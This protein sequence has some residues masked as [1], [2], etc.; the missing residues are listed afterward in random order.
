MQATSDVIELYDASGRVITVKD[1]TDNALATL[2]GIAPEQLRRRAYMTREEDKD[3]RI[4]TELLKKKLKGQ[5]LGWI[6][7]EL[8]ITRPTLNDKIEG[9]TEFLPSQIR[10]LTELLRLTP[11]EVHD[12]FLI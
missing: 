11:E 5:K 2:L 12:I 1:D 10:K 8:G 9:R 4:D 3:V 7:D 6:A